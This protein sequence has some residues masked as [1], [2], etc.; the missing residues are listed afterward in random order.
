MTIFQFPAE[1]GAVP[2]ASA[3]QHQHWTLEGLKYDTSDG[4]HNKCFK[5]EIRKKSSFLE[6]KKNR[7]NIKDCLLSTCRSKRLSY[8]M[9]N[10]IRI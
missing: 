7:K 2:Q 8:I 6:R 5:G 10:V 1:S 9:H 4:N 3:S